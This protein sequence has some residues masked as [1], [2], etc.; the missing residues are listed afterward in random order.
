MHKIV[1][2]KNSKTVNS[3]TLQFYKRNNWQSNRATYLLI[4]A[5]TDLPTQV[6]SHT[7]FDIIS[8]GVHTV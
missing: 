3:K 6:K 4:I 7:P 2:D 1:L 5:L 8:L